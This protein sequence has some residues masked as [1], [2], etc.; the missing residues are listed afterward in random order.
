MPRKPLK[1]FLIAAVLGLLAACSGPRVKLEKCHKPQEYQAATL[2]PKVRIP[3]GLEP[4]D[5]ELR[6]EIPY[7]SA[8]TT[9]TPRAQPC[10]VDPPSYMDRGPN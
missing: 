5:P 3:E 1:L 2:G 9:P 6:L 10:L 4:L 7:G 8:N